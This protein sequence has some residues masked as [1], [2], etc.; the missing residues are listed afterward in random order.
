MEK[1][2]CFKQQEDM[3]DTLVCVRR[4]KQE[5]SEEWDESMPLPGDIIEGFAENNADELFVP[6][7]AKSDLSSQ[8]GKISPQT[9][10][11]WLK[12]RRGERTLK[13]RARVMPD[14]SAVLQRRFTIKAANDDRH[15]AVLGDL[16]LEQCTELQE[17]SRKVVNMD[18]WAFSKRG[19][20]YDWKMKVDNY[21]P[22]QRSSV[23]SSILFMPL[24]GEHSIEATTGRCMAWFSAAVSSGAPIVFVNI[25]TEQTLNVEKTLCTGKELSWGGQKSNNTPVQILQGIRLWFLPGVAEILLEMIPEPGETRFGMDIKRIDEGFICVCSVTKGSAAER[26]GLSD[27]FEEANK[28]GHLL[29]ISRLEGKSL[30]PSSVCSMGLIHC[31]DQNEVKDTLISSIDEMDSIQIHLMAWPNQTHSSNTKANGV[32]HLQPPKGL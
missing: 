32:A 19:V 25:Q 6:A 24:Q 13:L 31:C 27:L 8:L 17:M 10:T 23:V 14:K 15:V 26:A 22:D 11:V 29:V 30:M 21:L 16:T 28:V 7:K 20:K 4:V 5:A 2:F 12:V 3:A 18:S 1:Y 9:E